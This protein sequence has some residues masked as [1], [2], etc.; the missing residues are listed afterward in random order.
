MSSNKKKNV[1]RIGRAAAQG[2]DEAPGETASPQEESAARGK[3]AQWL[4]QVDGEVERLR[5]RWSEALAELDRCETKNRELEKA[6][7]QLR[8]EVN[9]LQAYIDGRKAHWAEMQKRIEQYEDTLAG[10]EQ[11]VR[12][13]E[14]K[15]S[16]KDGERELL[17]NR[18]IE[19]ER[20]CSELAGRL[21][22]RER[23][24]RDDQ[25]RLQQSTDELDGL[26]DALARA[27]RIAD[28]AANEA[29]EQTKLAESL[30]RCVTRRDKTIE[31]LEHKL[32][33]QRES[34]KAIEAEKDERI[35]RFEQ[36]IAA[37]RT[38]LAKLGELRE[39]LDEK[40]QQLERIQSERD[41]LEAQAYDANQR[42]AALERRH[43]G[44]AVEVRSLRQELVAQQHLIGK[45]EAELDAKQS[46][47]ERL[48]SQI[49]AAGQAAAPVSGSAANGAAHDEVNG[50]ADASE[51]VEIIRIGELFRHDLQSDRRPIAVLEGPDGTTYPVTKPSVTIGR[52]SSNDICI[53]REFVSRIHA[54]LI[55]RG[56]GAI[57][58]DAG[59]TNGILVNSEPVGRRLLADGDIVSLGG[60]LD[61]KYI[62][63][64]ASTRAGVPGA[65]A[66]AKT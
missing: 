50:S 11:V 7:G 55:V 47:I 28:E 61:L 48:Q 43:G 35:A 24:Q 40:V 22:E 64:D 62:E 41:K 30:E 45:L 57:I 49:D 3:A 15:L 1:N 34:A 20:R 39:Q 21:Q 12:D 51:N 17:S 60:K 8:A 52:S 65:E 13:A 31:E 18:I 58:E 37:Q 26:R 38:E 66:Q 16:R 4:E 54:R 32:E 46:V 63:L 53:R 6:N 14:E 42:L 25:R 5:S 10:M 27:E 59:S 33:E 44:A 19:L 2:S 29:R 56:I 23:S 36:E 9:D